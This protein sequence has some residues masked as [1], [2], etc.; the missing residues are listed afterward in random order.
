AQLRPGALDFGSDHRGR[1]IGRVGGPMLVYVTV[2]TL[3][4]STAHASYVANLCSHL[5]QQTR[6]LMIGCAPPEG[7]T[8]DRLRQFWG[9]PFY[10]VDIELWPVPSIRTVGSH[11]R[12]ASIAGQMLLRRRW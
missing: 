7:A 4:S 1:G 2:A 12:A 5:G 10:G 8:I 9:L 11:L 6:V 3:P